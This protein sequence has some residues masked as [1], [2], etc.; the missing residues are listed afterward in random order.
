MMNINDRLK[1]GAGVVDTVVFQNRTAIDK[2]IASSIPLSI[3]VTDPSVSKLFNT[4]IVLS[5]LLLHSSITFI[6]ISCF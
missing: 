5:N 1:F 4:F 6:S 2:N 3:F